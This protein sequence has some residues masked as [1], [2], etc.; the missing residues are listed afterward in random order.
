[1]G[2]VREPWPLPPHSWLAVEHKSQIKC[3][4]M[5]QEHASLQYDRS[6]PC[7]CMA[8]YANGLCTRTCSSSCKHLRTQWC[9]FLEQEVREKR[10]TCFPSP[11]CDITREFQIYFPKIYTPE[12]M[13]G[14][15][16]FRYRSFPT[17]PMAIDRL[18]A[19]A[20]IFWSTRSS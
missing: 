8:I 12:Y 16:L 4:C 3:S 14:Y 2:G 18:G 9:K 15:W 11:S 7:R 17:Q 1:M 10:R 6:S 5:F 20:A 19:Q 13:P